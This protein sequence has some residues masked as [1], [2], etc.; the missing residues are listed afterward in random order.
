MNNFLNQKSPLEI[1][2][3]ISERLK[4]KRKKLK[5]S[6]EYLSFKSDVSLGSIKRFE[7]QYEI[8]LTSLIKIAIALDCESD[9]EELFN[10]KTYT[11]IAEV[12]NE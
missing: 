7:T 3:K 2:K 9:F 6:Q 11:S 8:S 4:Q 10:K 12:I 5:I 1:S